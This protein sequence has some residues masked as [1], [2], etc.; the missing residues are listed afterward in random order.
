MPR[1]ARSSVETCYCHVINR[2]AG[3]LPLFTRPR[4][5]RA[6]LDILRDGL[7]MHPV[8]LIAYCVMSNHWHLVVGP[9]GTTSLSRLLHWVETTHAVR[10]HRHRKT[11]GE[12]PVYQGRFKAH[13]IEEAGGLVRTCR[14]VERNALTAGLVRRAQDWPWG[15]LA[16]RRR[17]E[18]VLPLAGA[19]FLSSDAWIHLVNAALTT[20]ELTLQPIWRVTP[21]RRP[22]NVETAVTEPV[23][24]RPVPL[25]GN[26]A[27]PPGT[28]HGQQLGSVLRG[29]DQDQ[30]DAH[31]ERAEHLRLVKLPR[32]LKP[33]E[34][35]RH[36]PAFAIK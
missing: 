9:T 31:V 20:R 13:L 5:Y 33:R 8:P 18:P 22:R 14:Y 19:D 2:A 1:R 30:A 11:L 16:E 26:L 4:D 3:R 12:G 6:F 34:N 7:V 25:C 17:I 21:T 36:L 35:R 27:E 10:L 23:E 28:G 15:S 32:A 24:S 29:A